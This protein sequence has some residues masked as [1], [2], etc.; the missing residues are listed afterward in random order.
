MPLRVLTSRSLRLTVVATGFS[1]VVCAVGF[2]QTAV[3]PRS[4][5]VASIKLSPPDDGGLRIGVSGQPR[6]GGQWISRNAT[7]ASIIRAAYPGH[8]LPDQLVGGPDWLNTT[9]FDVTGKASSATAS[10]EELVAMQRALL[11][12]RFK[13]VLRAET[14]QASGYALVLARPGSVHRALRASKVDCDAMRAATLR[15][16]KA[17]PAT[18]AACV[19]KLSQNGPVWRLVAAGFALPRLAD[20]LSPTLGAPVVDATGLAGAFDFTLEFL[21]EPSAA[22]GSQ[23]VS[24]FAALEEQLGLRLER[25]R[26]PMQVLVVDRAEL[27]TP[28]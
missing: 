10:R 13:L 4:F 12:E 23:S 18:A 28:D 27:P 7:L 14:R 9:E 22:P 15:G 6:P 25:R 2:A 8:P 17:D 19:V 11:A 24:V 16:D 26:L 1:F 3:K 5:E 20:T 21:T